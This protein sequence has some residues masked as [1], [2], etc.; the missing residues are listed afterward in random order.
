MVGEQPD[1]I[2]WK[3]LS[4]PRQQRMLKLRE[5]FKHC[6]EKWSGDKA[7]GVTVQPVA[8]T[9]GRSKDCSIIQPHKGPLKRSGWAL[10]ILKIKQ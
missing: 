6:Q 5:G 3:A 2:V 8:K 9:S 10:Q 7:K 1:L 4:L